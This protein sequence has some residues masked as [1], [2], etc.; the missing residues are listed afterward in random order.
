VLALLTLYDRSLLS[1]KET[2]HKVV[3]RWD[4]IL[5]AVKKKISEFINI[6]LDFNTCFPSIDILEGF[7]EI[8]VIICLSAKVKV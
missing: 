1:I 6:H 2:F 8:K 7:E 3:G 5:D 4:S